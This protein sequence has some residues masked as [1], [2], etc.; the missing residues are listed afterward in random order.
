MGKKKLVEMDQVPE[1]QEKIISLI[2]QEID[3]LSDKPSLS[4]EDTKTLIAFSNTLSTLYKDYRAECLAI[5][6]DLKGKAKSDILEIVKA[7][8]K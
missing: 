6:K 7:D 8:G 3:V 4:V 1:I 2:S 5:S